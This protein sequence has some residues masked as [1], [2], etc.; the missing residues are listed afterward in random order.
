ANAEA[1]S[2][3]VG[4]KYKFAGKEFEDD[5]GKNTVAYEWRDYDPAIARFNKV[6]RFAEKYKNTSPY[7]FALNS[8]LR[9]SEIAGDSIN[10]RAIQDFDQDN[11]TNHTGSLVGSLSGITGLSLSVNDSGQLTYAKDRDGN[12]IIS[13]NT[14]ENGNSIDSGSESA[15]N[16][17]TAAISNE[18]TG[19]GRID[20]RSSAPRGG[21]LIKISPNQIESFM[22]GARNLNS[23]T[24]GYGMTFLHEMHHSALGLGVGDD[25]SR[26]GS[27]GGVVDRL[28]VIR[29]ELGSD[30]GQRTSYRAIRFNG[31]NSFLPMGTGA[32]NNLQNSILPSTSNHKFIKF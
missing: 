30:Y 9:Y 7:Q 14:D 17:L 5:L 8:P 22:N 11:N 24:L 32:L 15:R 10:L 3:N 16:D 4:Q 21:L 1:S 26:L 20:D 25:R 18:S 27:T 23:E 29:S 31:G 2:T 28:N 12:A 19:Y 6:D 13:Q